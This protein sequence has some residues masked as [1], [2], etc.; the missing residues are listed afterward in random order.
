MPAIVQSSHLG[1]RLSRTRHC[2]LDILGCSPVTD[3]PYQL[4]LLHRPHRLGA[5]RLHQL[6]LAAQLLQLCPPHRLF[7]ATQL[8]Q[9]HPL[10]DLLLH[11][12][13]RYSR[14]RHYIIARMIFGYRVYSHWECWSSKIYPIHFRVTGL[15]IYGFQWIYLLWLYKY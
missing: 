14:L 6:F 4:R 9:L 2:G 10:H 7:L 1:A 13:T 12:I 3:P 11:H 5:T 8:L 15:I